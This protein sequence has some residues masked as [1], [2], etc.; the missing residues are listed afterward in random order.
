MVK[1]KIIWPILA[2]TAAVMMA[3]CSDK[4]TEQEV[5][6]MG[7]ESLATDPVPIQQQAQK[8]ETS[9]QTEPG[10]KICTIWIS[11]WIKAPQPDVENIAQAF[12]PLHLR[13]H[14]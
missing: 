1:K 3:G 10:R 9:A 11:T 12:Y 2:L 4:N 7:T 14:H 5:P 6:S 13:L 8:E